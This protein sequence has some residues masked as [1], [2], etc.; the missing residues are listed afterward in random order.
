MK[1]LLPRRQSSQS[2]LKV[3]LAL[4][5]LSILTVAG[6]SAATS[7][8][9]EQGQSAMWLTGVVSDTRCGSTHGTKVHGDAGCT[10]LC[11]KLGAGYALAVGQKIYVLRGHQGELNAFAGDMVVVRGK[12]VNHNTIAV[13]SVAPYTVLATL[14]KY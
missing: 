5:V 7:I 6:I 13:E 8:A 9:H 10:R 4:A 12:I 1:R 2:I 3:L 11:V 14:F